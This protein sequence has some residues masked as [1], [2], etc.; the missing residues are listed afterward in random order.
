MGGASLP[1]WVCKLNLTHMLTEMSSSS[2]FINLSIQHRTVKII[3]SL[4]FPWFISI[5][6]SDRCVSKNPLTSGIKLRHMSQESRILFP[7]IQPYKELIP[8]RGKHRFPLHL[9]QG[10]GEKGS[11]ENWYLSY[12][13]EEM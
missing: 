8:I 5:A 13:D 2:K 3:Q 9:K 7:L 6:N 12:V 1:L 10:M 4:L 11:G